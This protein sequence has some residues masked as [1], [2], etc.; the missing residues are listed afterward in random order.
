MSDEQNSVSANNS[1]VQFGSLANEETVQKLLVNI[2]R[3]I[4]FFFI[5]LIIL[6]I[7]NY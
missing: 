7:K 2:Y 6:V 5:F 3:E 4:I 1:K